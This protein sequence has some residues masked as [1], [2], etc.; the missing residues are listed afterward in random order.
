MHAI[1]LRLA[2]GVALAVAA[3]GASAAAIVADHAA[4]DAFAAIPDTSFQSVREHWRFFYG[5]TSHGSQVCTGLDMLAAREPVRWADVTM[6]EFAGDLGVWGDLGWVA[7]TR[8]YLAVHPECNA[9]LWSWCGGATDNTPAGIDAYLR[10]MDQL[11][12]DFPRVR[13]VYM[14]GHLDGTGPNG[15][16]YQNNNRIRTWCLALDKVLYDFADIESWN[17]D[18]TYF[19]DGDAWCAWCSE[20]CATHACPPCAECAHSQCINCLRKGQAFWWMMARLNGWTPGSAPPDTT[21]TDSTRTPGTVPAHPNPFERAT[22]LTFTLAE[23]GLVRLHVVDAA[24][25][26]V[27]TVAEATLPAGRHELTW[28]GLTDDGRPAPS[29]V[30]FARLVG[31]GLARNER[32]V[33][34]K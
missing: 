6:T 32:I 30:Y 10:A 8:S 5:H 14:T 16:L 18:G 31:P 22:T 20:W 19:P 12:K 3:R 17:P 24:G 2:V 9:V 29:G 15:T 34:R 11:E 4:A 21:T 33:V 27:A 26:R 1:V 25:R 7:P 13:F 23:P 28:N